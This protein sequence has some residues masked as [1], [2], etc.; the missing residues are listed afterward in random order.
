MTTPTVPMPGV[1]PHRADGMAASRGRL[2]DTLSRWNG[3][4]PAAAADSVWVPAVSGALVLV[5]GAMTLATGQP[6]LFAALGPTAVMIAASPGHSATRFHSIVLGHLCAFL[7]AWLAV[8][9]VG[10]HD[11][12][13][14][15]GP[16]TLSAARVWASA[17]AVAVT[18]LV[19][20]SIRA[21]HPPAA[22][23]ALLVTLGM[24]RIT[25]KSSASMM[26]GVLLVAL[27]GEWFQRIRVRERLARP[28]AA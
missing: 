14:I 7:C 10:A 4:S 12:P 20:P 16:H 13:T 25:W 9:L 19:Q 27:V 28:A 11:A 15:F 26:A 21:Y 2:S 22:C 3:R 8:L 24:Y 1:P 23:T 6:W 17:L 18:V 5:A